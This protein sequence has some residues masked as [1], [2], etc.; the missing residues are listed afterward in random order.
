MD[1]EHMAFIPIM[2]DLSGYVGAYKMTA[3]VN[4]DGSDATD[5]NEEYLSSYKYV[6]IAHVHTHGTTWENDADHHWNACACGDKSNLAAHADGDGDGKCD[7][8]MYQLSTTSGGS[9]NQGGE[10]PDGSGSQGGTDTPVAEEG[11]LGA[12]AIVAIVIGSVLVAGIGGFALFWFVIKKKSWADF[13]AIF[14][15]NKA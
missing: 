6:K 2:A 1:F 10:N 11:G 4:Q 12:G 7:A 9:G 15:K 3:G 13:V 5:F 8:C 14:K